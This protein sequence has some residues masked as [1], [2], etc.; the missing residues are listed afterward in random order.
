MDYRNQPDFPYSLDFSPTNDDIFTLKKRLIDME[1]TFESERF[2]LIHDFTVRLREE[3]RGRAELLSKVAELEGV[4]M[5]LERELFESKG[6]NYQFEG[7]NWENQ[8]N[9]E[10]ERMKNQLKNLEMQ[11]NDEKRKFEAQISNLQQENSLFRDEIQKFE[12]NTSE[13][14]QEN[15]FLRLENQRLNQEN[16]RLTSKLQEFVGL[17]TEKPVN[18]YAALQHR[19][20]TTTFRIKSLED[21]ITKQEKTLKNEGKRP[22]SV[23]KMRNRPRRS[24]VKEDLGRKMDGKAGKVVGKREK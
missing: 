18:D 15:S 2:R 8:T 9:F 4:K 12:G 19:L 14:R 3:E 23:T 6:E 11:R 24:Q 16:D 21:L 10:V 17:N 20:E 7:K 22:K 5:R 1:L 13:I